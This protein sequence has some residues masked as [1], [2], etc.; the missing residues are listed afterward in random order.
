MTTGIAPS[1]VYESADDI[2]APTPP[3]GGYGTIEKDAYIA[4]RE[5]P[6]IEPD[7]AP[8]LRPFGDSLNNETQEATTDGLDTLSQV[9]LRE[10]S[11]ET[12][13][14]LGLL[15]AADTAKRIELLALIRNIRSR[16][17]R[18]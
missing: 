10:L 9:E 6:D 18:T 7:Q 3:D 15:S 12:Y 8:R 5:T 16:L 1:E 14:E 13:K 17:E 2:P 4:P 11:N